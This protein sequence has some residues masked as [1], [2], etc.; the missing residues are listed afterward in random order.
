MNI[1]ID[2]I[3]L[4]ELKTAKDAGTTENTLVTTAVQAALVEAEVE[5]PETLNNKQGVEK[6]QALVK[7]YGGND[8]AKNTKI[9]PNAEEEADTYG[10]DMTLAHNQAAYEMLK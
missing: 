7:E 8:G 5:A 2:E 3:F 9:I 10:V 6:L 4:A 1:N